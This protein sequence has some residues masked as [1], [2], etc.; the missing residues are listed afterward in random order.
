MGEDEV[1]PAAVDVDLIAEGGAVH[2]RALDVPAGAALAPR[3]IPADLAGLGRLPEREVVGMALCIVIFDAHAVERV[4][5]VPPRELPVGGEGIDVKVDVTVVCGISV[6]RGDERLHKGNDVADVLR[7]LEPEGG[8]VHI[9]LAHHMVDLFYHHLGILV[10]RDARLL[11]AGDDLVVHVGVV[12][13]IRHLVALFFE[14]LAEDIVEHRLKGV[15]DVGLARHRDAAGIHLDLPLLE[16]HKFFLSSR[17]RIINFHLVSPCR[18][19]LFPAPLFFRRL[20]PERS[21][22]YLSRRA[23]PPKKRTFRGAPQA[24]RCARAKN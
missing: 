9:E 16:G 24:R 18:L 6:P 8:V 23:S 15:A 12:A 22:R 20:H 7:R 13:G 14:E 10:R 19:S 3:R 11:G 2:R 5:L 1:S 4:L 21:L 17:Q